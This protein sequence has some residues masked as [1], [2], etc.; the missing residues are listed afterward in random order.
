MLY[1]VLYNKNN[2]S[3]GYVWI[4]A[5]EIISQQNADTDGYFRSLESLND[6]DRKIVIDCIN[7]MIFFWRFNYCTAYSRKKNHPNMFVVDSN[8]KK[9]KY[10]VYS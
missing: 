1:S 3:S 7:M 5:Y 10:F 2:Y 4:K 8:V 9:A 6:K